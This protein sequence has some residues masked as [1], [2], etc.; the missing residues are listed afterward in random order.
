[1]DS[2]GTRHIYL[3]IIEEMVKELKNNKLLKKNLKESGIEFIK[4]VI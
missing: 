3:K 4:E 2:A 1:M